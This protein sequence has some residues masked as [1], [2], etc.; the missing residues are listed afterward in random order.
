MEELSLHEIFSRP[1]YRKDY[2]IAEAEN[3]SIR[4]GGFAEEFGGTSS[5]PENMV[6]ALCKRCQDQC[7]SLS[8]KRR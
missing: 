8:E 1:T 4:C 5:R 3:T 2:V 7:F 6:S